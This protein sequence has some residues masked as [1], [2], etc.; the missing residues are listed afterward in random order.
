MHFFD[1]VMQTVDD[2]FTDSPVRRVQRITCSR[3]IGERRFRVASQRVVGRIIN[4][5]KAIG[6]S[7]FVAFTRM[8]VDNI[9]NDLDPPDAA[10]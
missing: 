5:F 7:A 10:P 4:A 1:P 9:N 8:I 6:W 3:V 2:Q